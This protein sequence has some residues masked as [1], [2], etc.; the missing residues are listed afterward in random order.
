MRE[1]IIQVVLEAC[2]L[3]ASLLFLQRR[4]Q[5]GRG[6]LEDMGSDQRVT[7][8]PMLH[9]ILE[10]VAH[11]RAFKALLLLQELRR[12]LQSCRT[13]RNKRE[14]SIEVLIYLGLR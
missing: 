2:S 3:Q 5:L 13:K 9:L 4:I 1:A 10:E 8:G 12:C 6:I 7:I 11:F 14:Y